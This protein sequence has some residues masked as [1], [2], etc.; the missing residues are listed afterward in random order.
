MDFLRLFESI[1]SFSSWKHGLQAAQ[2]N[3][4]EYRKCHES[5]NKEEEEEEEEEEPIFANNNASSQ[6]LEETV[7]HLKDDLASNSARSRV[8]N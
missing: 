6:K 4:L 3:L 7:L 2:L 1:L 5:Y 8:I